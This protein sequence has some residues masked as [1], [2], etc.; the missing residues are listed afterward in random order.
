[1]S[2]GTAKVFYRILFQNKVLFQEKLGRRRKIP[3]EDASINSPSIHPDF[4]HAIMG[5]YVFIMLILV[6]WILPYVFF[7]FTMVSMTLLFFNAIFIFLIFPL[8]GPL[9]YK[10]SLVGIGNLVGLVWEYFLA[11]LIANML[12]YFGNVFGGLCFMLIPFL[13]LVWIVS[14]W[15]LGL[16]ILASKQ[17]TREV[18]AF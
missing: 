18:K 15:A 10:F 13:E 17:K 14:M 2:T 6:L 8:N 9:L 1:M 11:Y 5:G 16:S 7:G 4:F 3:P 12:Y